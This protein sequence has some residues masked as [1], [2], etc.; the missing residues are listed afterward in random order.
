MNKPTLKKYYVLLTSI[1]FFILHIPFVFAKNKP[2]NEI[3]PQSPK[4]ETGGVRG[5]S[6]LTLA[7]TRIHSTAASIYDSMRLNLIGL[8]QQSF[9]YAIQGFNY[10]VETGKLVNDK[11]I[12]IVDFSLPSSQKR[13]FV[14]DLENYKVLFNTYVAHGRQSGTLMANQFSNIPE[15]LQSSLG[16]YETQGTYNGHNGY[17]MR[18]EG[19]EHGINDNAGNR[20][21]VM[22]GADYVNEGMIKSRGYIG[23]SWGC[24]ALPPQL[25]KPII[26]KIKNGSCLFIYSPDKSYLNKSKI[27]NAAA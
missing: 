2:F 15:S 21:I 27:L 10:L 7:R 19:L 5:D 13:L 11:V 6:L 23:R 25:N 1:C 3:K 24:P 18:L 16:F 8:S 26:D 17:S 9:D 14:I 4:M 12:S 22:H 20:S